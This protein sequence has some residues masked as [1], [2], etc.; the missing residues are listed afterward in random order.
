LKITI[1][2]PE[3]SGKTTIAR[4]LALV[5]ETPWVP[6][7]AREY[8]DQLDRP[9]Q[10]SDLLEIARG[11]LA[12]EKEMALQAGELLFCD[13]SLEVIKIW[14][15]YRYGRCHPWILEQLQK[16]RPALYLLCV[17]D[18]A[19]EPDPQR[20]NED[21]REALYKIYKSELSGQP[22]AKVWGKG[23]QRIEKAIAAV[24]SLM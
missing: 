11:Q 19:W 8:I 6:E 20:E 17:P 23:H 21:D 7:H 15:E 10:E 4:Q 22:L 2:G 13:T 1:T 3:S 5:Y 14:S 16:N 9:Y 12:K 24:Q 18:L